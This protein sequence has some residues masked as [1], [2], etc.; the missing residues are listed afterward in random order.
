MPLTLGG[1][2][3]CSKVGA[4]IIA[5]WLDFIIRMGIVLVSTLSETPHM[6]KWTLPLLGTAVATL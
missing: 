4:D 6:T 5:A 2:G 3:W 1:M